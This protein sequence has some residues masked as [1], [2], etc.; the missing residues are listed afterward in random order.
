MSMYTFRRTDTGQ[1][2]NFRGKGANHAHAQAVV[3]F[4]LL[5]DQVHLVQEIRREGNTR[6][7]NKPWRQ[8]SHHRAGR[9]APTQVRWIGW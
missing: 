3:N 7:G 8:K 2:I 6:Q 1:Q 4:G 9:P 5:A